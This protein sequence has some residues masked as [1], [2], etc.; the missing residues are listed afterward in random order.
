MKEH[1]ILFS[2][3]LAQDVHD[4]WK[5]QTRRVIPFGPK[6]APHGNFWKPSEW[7]HEGKLWG[8]QAQLKEGSLH[9]RAGIKCRYGRVG[10]HL[11][12]REAFYDHGA[13]LGNADPRNNIEYRA[14][15]FD[16]VDDSDANSWKPSIHMPRWASRTLLEITDL[17]IE[18]L[19]AITQEDAQA[20]G[21]IGPVRG[22][23]PGHDYIRE[24][25]RLWDGI[26]AK[27]D[28]GWDVNPWVF[29]ITFKVLEVKD[30]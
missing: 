17:R 1:P 15:P 20:E 27:R 23:L 28:F 2:S 25:R 13:V 21:I 5:T 14:C 12:V 30:A 9:P 6:A 18:R 8:W 29:A 4:G 10:D 22:F 26:N 11:W 7:G 19:Q 3:Y 16:R 24:F